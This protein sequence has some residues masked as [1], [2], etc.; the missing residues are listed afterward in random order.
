MGYAIMTEPTVRAMTRAD[1]PAIAD[2]LDHVALFPKEMLHDLAAPYLN[3]HAEH[4]WLVA[5]EGNAITGFAYCEPERATEGCF[6]LLAIAVAADRQR[7]GHG[8]R[9]I[10]GLEAELAA[11]RARILLVETSAL[12]AYAGARAFYPRC[13][14]TEEAR[15]RDFYADG[16]DKIVFWKRLTA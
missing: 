1:L 7:G 14:F 9:L 2:L 16:D 11:R 13:G 3:G 8:A 5:A 15:L 10:A 4:L 12:P 6:N